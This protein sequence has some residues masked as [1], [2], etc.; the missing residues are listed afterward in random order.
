[1]V[2]GDGDENLA[3]MRVGIGAQ[4]REVV[5]VAGVVAERPDDGPFGRGADGEEF[6]VAGEEMAVVDGAVEKGA[7]GLEFG[8][9][10]G[11]GADGVENGGSTV[12]DGVAFGVDTGEANGKISCHSV[13]VFYGLMDLM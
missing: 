12:A 5:G 1:M 8:L 11:S 6:G 13:W 4:Q 7:A 2:A 3:Q 9:A 10:A